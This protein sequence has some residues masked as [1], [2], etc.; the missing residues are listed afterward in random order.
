M[1]ECVDMIYVKWC[2]ERKSSVLI[3][4]QL[5]LTV[6]KPKNRKKNTILW[7]RHCPNKGQHIEIYIYG[8]KILLLL[9]TTILHFFQCE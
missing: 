2:I 8:K 9:T 6:E 4:F 5:G 1:C 7:C 3:F